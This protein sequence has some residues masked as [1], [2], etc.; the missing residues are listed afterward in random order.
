MPLHSVP[1]R[2][3]IIARLILAGEVSDRWPTYVHFL[4][5]GYEHLANDNRIGPYYVSDATQ[6]RN[7]FY[8]DPQSARWLPSPV[9]IVQWDETET[10]SCE[11]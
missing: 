7:A 5:S 9:G 10:C 8:A 3:R 4:A 6:R 2:P 1:T 11:E